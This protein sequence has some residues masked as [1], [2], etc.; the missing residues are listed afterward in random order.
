LIGSSHHRHDR[1]AARDRI[2]ALLA[3]RQRLGG[4][5]EDP[6]VAARGVRDRLAFLIGGFDLLELYEDAGALE[7]VPQ[8][9][10]AQH[11]LRVE[12]RLDGAR[13][14]GGLGL[15]QVLEDAPQVE[16]HG[17]CLLLLELDGDPVV[18]VLAL[19]EE[20]ALSRFAQGTH[21]EL[22]DSVVLGVQVAHRRLL[23][24]A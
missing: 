9:D 12:R 22:F 2:V 3:E 20:D 11:E 1:A 21:G 8:P 17:L 24:M 14:G 5:Q 18:A 7:L 4:R 16:R 15:G 19:Q 10:L 6:D 23:T 13:P